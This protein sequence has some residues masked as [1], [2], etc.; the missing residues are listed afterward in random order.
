MK[1]SLT[2]RIIAVFISVV[3]LATSLPFVAFGA[4]DSIV[5]PQTEWSLVASTDFRALGS[6]ADFGANVT[7]ECPTTPEGGN[8]ITWTAVTD[9]QFSDYGTTVTVTDEGLYI[10]SGYMYMSGYGDNSGLP[11]KGA[12]SFKIDVEFTLHHDTYGAWGTTSN[13]G[14]RAF[15]T[16][17][18]TTTLGFENKDLTD[19]TYA[20]TQ[21]LMGATYSYGQTI[22]DRNATNYNIAANNSRLTNDEMYH[23]IV[24]YAHGYVR[25]Y[26]TNS[27]GRVMM[28]YAGKQT[29][30]NTPALTSFCLGADNTASSYY[31]MGVTYGS[32]K[33]YTGV[34]NTTVKVDKDMSRDK[35]LFAYFCSNDDETIKFAVSD[36]GLN[37]EALNG[38]NPILDLNPSEF[39]PS[40]GNSVG[41]VASGNARDPFIVQARNADGSVGKGY[42]VVATDLDTALAWEN[43]KFLIWYIDDLTNADTAK[44]WSVETSGWYDNYASTTSSFYAWAPEVIWDYA[45]QAYMIYWSG[46]DEGYNNLKLHYA[47][48]RDFKSF[49]QDAQCTLQLGTTDA[50][51]N[52]VECQR[53]VA[54]DMVKHIDGN[55]TFNGKRY[56]LFFKDETAQQIYYATSENCS[57]PYTGITKFTDSDYKD[58]CE[59]PEVYQL[60]DSSYVLLMDYYGSSTGTFLMYSSATLDGFQDVSSGSVNSVGNSNINHVSPR[61]GAVTYISTDEYN[62]LVEKFGKATFDATGLKPGEAVNDTLVARYFTTA[63]TTYDATGNGYTLTN[64]G[65]GVTATVFDGKVAGQFVSNSS[66]STAD[67]AVNGSYSYID[68]SAML[69][70]EDINAKD[71]VTFDWYGYST[72]NDNGR[73]FDISNQTI[74]ALTWDTRG[75]GDYAYTSSS[76][77]FGANT[78]IVNAYNGS[79]NDGWH[80]YTCTMSNGFMT[81]YVDG[82]LQRT[83]F[84]KGEL[85]KQ[86]SPITIAALNEA[87]FQSV[88]NGNLRFG[89]STFNGDVMLDGYISDFR[90]YNRALSYYD[91]QD[92]LELLTAADSGAEVNETNVDDVRDFYDPMEDMDTDGD[93]TNDKTAYTATVVDSIHN[94]VLNSAGG[95]TAHNPATTANVAKSDK[96][97]TISM[98]Y[99]PGSSISTEAIFEIG[100]GAGG[101][102]VLEISED[103]QFG[104]WNNNNGYIL[105]NG[106]FGDSGLSVNTWSHITLQIIPNGGFD[107]IYVYLNGS[108]VNVLDTFVDTSNLNTLSKGESIVNYLQ[109]EHTVY[110]GVSCGHIYGTGTC[111]D[112]YIDD[113]SIYSGI[114]N[115][116]DIYANDNKSIA[117]KLIDLAIQEFKTKMATVDDNTST[118]FTNMAAAYDAYDKACR[119]KDAIQ[120]GGVTPD[121]AQ[122]TEIYME[123]HSAV[124]SMGNY[125]KP[126]T[127]EGLSKADVGGSSVDINKIYTQNMLSTRNIMSW[128]EAKAEYSGTLGTSGNYLF[129]INTT[130]FVWLYD[131]TTTLTAPVN[132]GGYTN[133]S[134]LGA[135]GYTLCS[136]YVSSGDVKFG[137]L[138]TSNPHIHYTDGYWNFDTSNASDTQVMDWIYESTTITPVNGINSTIDSYRFSMSDTKYYKGSNYLTYTGT[139]SDSQYYITVPITYT[140]VFSTNST[141]AYG[142]TSTTSTAYVINYVPVKNALFDANR[143]NILANITNYSPETARELLDAYDALTS[144]SY[145]FNTISDSDVQN[146]ASTLE[147][148]VNTLLGVDLTA[149]K[150]KADYTTLGDTAV[151]YADFINNAVFDSET[152]LVIADSTFGD[153]DEKYTLASWNAL[154]DAYNDVVSHMASLHP[155]GDDN[156]YVTDNA[157][158]NR[159]IGILENSKNCLVAVADYE[160][161]D[162]VTAT[163]SETYVANSTG[164]GTSFGNQT[165]TY[166]SW[167]P[168]DNAYDAAEAIANADDVIRN[169]TPKYNNVI[170]TNEGNYASGRFLAVD[171]NGNYV[172]STSDAVAFVYNPSFYEYD[173]ETGT[174]VES[175]DYSGNYILQSDGTYLDVS[176][177]RYGAMRN[178]GADASDFSAAQLNINDKGQSVTD[179][180][181]ALDPVADY[182]VY[183]ATVNDLKKQDMAAFTSSYISSDSSVYGLVDYN[184]SQNGTE[185]YNTGVSFTR[186]IATDAYSNQVGNG[187]ITADSA[188][189]KNANQAQLDAQITA[190]LS[191]LTAANEDTS[192]AKRSQYNVTFKVNV[193]G[194]ETTVGTYTA[195]YG[196][197]LT[198]DASSAVGTATCNS[199]EVTTGTTR[200]FVNQANT[201]TLN[202]QSDATVVAYASAGTADAG[203]VAVSVLNQYNQP[204]HNVV[205]SGD[206]TIK[207]TANSVTIGGA[208]PIVLPTMPNYTIVGWTAAGYSYAI[209]LDKEYKVSD[210]AGSNTE[211][212]FGPTL[213]FTKAD[214]TV[215]LDGVQVAAGVYDDL[216]TVSSD[217]AGTVALALV[218]DGAYYVAA[219]GTT[220]DMYLNRSVDFVSIVKDGS[221]YY[222]SS[223][224]DANLITD[225]DMTNKL[226]GGLPFVYSIMAITG[227][228][229][230]GTNKFTTFTA[231]SKNCTIEVTEVG[232]LYSKTASTDDTL[233]IGGSGV[234]QAAAKNP[235]ATTNQ[236]SYTIATKGNLYT[237]GYVKYTVTY[238]NAGGSATMQ[239]IDYGNICTNVG[240]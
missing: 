90:I 99:N 39:Y 200:R 198:L 82:V 215:T 100:N 98:F 217:V 236:F 136:I 205:V 131:G 170:Y 227:Q 145:L 115:A 119:Y 194:V 128:S 2:K 105:A 42:Y 168:F 106:L 114:Y 61:H 122:A 68:L 228:N 134:S 13:A 41:T 24:Q 184:G 180:Y 196:D 11:I 219:Y 150:Q 142:T 16:I 52:F 110:Y 47:Y 201:Y 126:V 195:N 226:N 83:V 45:N 67:S 197:S 188:I 9:S 53:L 59:G 117:D 174:Y 238:T 50:N 218:Q 78:T 20:Y 127:I 1:K 116:T 91:I 185:T 63:D 231:T 222:F 151:S 30:I 54:P 148:K 37:F 12:Q 43:S 192:G 6:G 202:I 156:A 17:G 51:G 125:S 26:I 97:Y 64:G 23:Y 74:G 203:S 33:F 152:G 118:V 214:C 132:G 229:S 187:Y 103:G 232:T 211:L 186:D 92:S 182:S 3:M 36:D 29:S 88:F 171:I 22:Y 210:I 139:P 32:V 76:G 177:Y 87:W 46:G 60:N 143:L 237:R 34:D 21:D 55:I 154:L 221:N 199:W 5:A 193:D 172:T 18:T 190:I 146:L 235:S 212:I 69:S 107:L 38:N 130:P 8:P 123:V 181:K 84:S 121:P 224:S 65:T 66:V 140:G 70:A 225:T 93:G 112:G 19:S 175:L 230:S 94:N 144:Q 111:V 162:S 207:F 129:Y 79:Y 179:T 189:F 58:G 44:P 157:I 178:T 155:Y 233:V 96:G 161:V 102:S 169:N 135:K 164:N 176:A 109:G 104:Y 191:E 234:Y 183:N 240:M 239:C 28:S 62:A 173:S 138:G 113:F 95:V 4:D 15:A 25:T 206:T 71:G 141:T 160:P 7:G 149:I 48:T 57:G 223:V 80:H 77:E 75:N 73:Y 85:Q 213:S 31:G 108:L 167:I 89:V 166:G 158:I 86:G 27:T 14:R 120:Y 165:Y 35:Y 72:V 40:N 209:E 56:Y 137:G 101:T 153:G 133:R 49:Y 216:V 124:E 159:L 208:S 10:P 163:T 147:T 81:M 204:F 220:Y